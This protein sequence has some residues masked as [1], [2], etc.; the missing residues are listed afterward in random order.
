MLSTEQ[1]TKQIA[2]IN[3]HALTN[4]HNAPRHLEHAEYFQ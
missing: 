3:Q 2:L 1:V 4:I